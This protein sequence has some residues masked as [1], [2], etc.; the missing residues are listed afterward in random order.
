MLTLIGLFIAAAPP[1]PTIENPDKVVCRTVPI[2]GTRLK[3]GKVCKTQAE[4]KAFRDDMADSR[5][6]I[7][8]G[9]GLTFEQLKPRLVLMPDV[10]LAVL[11]C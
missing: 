8:K 1:E 9:G 11:V 10:P 3:K 6:H 2:L 7:Q 4:W 5:R